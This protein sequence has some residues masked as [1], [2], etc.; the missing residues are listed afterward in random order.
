M[1]KNKTDQSVRV[2]QRDKI[3]GQFQI[4]PL[5]WTQKQIEFINL[6]TAKETRLT[7]ISGPAGSSK[8]VL[9]TFCALTLLNQHRVSDIIYVRAAVES[10]DSKLGFLPGDLDEKISYYGIPFADKLEELLDKPTITLLDKE[11]RVQILPVNYL[12]GVSWNA[13]YI[14]VDEAQNL[15]HKELVTILTRIGKFTKCIVMADPCQSDISN[16]KGGGFEAMLKLFNDEESRQQ[17]IHTFE[18]KEEDIMRD[19]LTKFL[20]HKFKKFEEKKAEDLKRLT[21]HP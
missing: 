20:V 5:N 18:F 3:K 8:T 4:R 21:S 15:T 9:S 19:E 10:A 13:K 7:F 11:Q 17:G 6:A 2:P 12:R 1:S 16:G 14:L